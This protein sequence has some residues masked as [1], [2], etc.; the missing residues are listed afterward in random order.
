M[1]GSIC[2]FNYLEN[3]KQ[4]LQQ[5]K[6]EGGY[7]IMVQRIRTLANLLSRS[8]FFSIAANRPASAFSVSSKFL[9]Y[10][11]LVATSTST[12]TS[13]LLVRGGGSTHGSSIVHLSTSSS[14]DNNLD[15]DGEP[16]TG[17]L[18]NTEPKYYSPLEG[19]TTK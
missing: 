17:W 7:Y 11:R 14:S 19:D 3:R 18:H 1:A 9:Q 8:I 12:I 15:N 4:T 13:P 6:G 5:N 16:R 10:H 2:G